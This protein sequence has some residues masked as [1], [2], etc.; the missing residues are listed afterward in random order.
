MSESGHDGA[1]VERG[2]QSERAQQ[3]S[4]ALVSVPSVG[5]V[6]P[7]DENAPPLDCAGDDDEF[8]VKLDALGPIVLNVDGTMGRIA[9]WANFTEN[10]KSQAIRLISARNQR[11]KEALKNKAVVLGDGE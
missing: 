2:S 3:D 4:N 5:A 7:S 11:R 10:E 1:V 9:N 6:S 8:C